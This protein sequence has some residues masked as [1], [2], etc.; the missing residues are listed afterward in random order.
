MS[1]RNRRKQVPIITPIQLICNKR[2]QKMRVLE[3]PCSQ[4]LTKV[5][6]QGTDDIGVVVKGGRSGEY[7]EC[8]WGAFKDTGEWIASLC[9]PRVCGCTDVP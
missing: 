3:G 6:C 7:Y 8:T 1:E 4:N 9:A 2:K 5:S